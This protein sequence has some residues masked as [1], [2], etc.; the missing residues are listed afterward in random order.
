MI[1]RSEQGSW[2]ERYRK[3]CMKRFKADMESIKVRRAVID[4]LSGKH[5]LTEAY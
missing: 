3:V 2:S 5:A 4:P 1:N